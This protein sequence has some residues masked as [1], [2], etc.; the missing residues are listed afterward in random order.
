MRSWLALALVACHPAPPTR[1][2]SNTGAVVPMP[3]DVLGHAAALRPVIT[4][5]DTSYLLI[6]FVSGYDESASLPVARPACWSGESEPQGA[7]PTSVAIPDRA[8]PELAAL[9]PTLHVLGEDGPCRAAVGAPVLLS[10]AGCEPSASMVAPLTG[11]GAGLA[12]FASVEPLDADLRWRPAPPSASAP[13]T[14]ASDV[15]DPLL[16]QW[17]AGWLAEPAF[18]PAGRHEM[19]LVSAQVEAGTEALLGAEFAALMGTAADQCEWS[20]ET[21][22]LIGIRRGDTLTPL[23]GVPARWDGAV[24]WRGQIAG[25]VSG[26]PTSVTLVAVRGATVAPLYEQMIWSDNAECLMREWA[27]VSYPC[28]L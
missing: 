11:C 13:V 23:D 9:P 3:L 1:A 7:C 2:L 25:V 20:V 28:G 6:S 5:G 12:P 17:V 18:A 24:A 26:A 16:A 4:H 27:G 15:R 22:D 10:T 19:R 14:R 21:R 8:S